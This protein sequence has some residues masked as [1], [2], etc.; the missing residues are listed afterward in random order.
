[1]I[2]EVYA[3]TKTFD[4]MYEI[5]YMHLKIA[6][7]GLELRV[8]LKGSTKA[9][10]LYYILKTFKTTGY[11]FDSLKIWERFSSQE[12]KKLREIINDKNRIKLFSL[13]KDLRN[14]SGIDGLRIKSSED[15]LFIG[16]GNPIKT[17]HQDFL[18]VFYSFM[19][20]K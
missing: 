4:S 10:S 2:G 17:S 18:G 3:I 7:P 9:L 15:G 8:S 5:D 19:K 14:R 12:E 20:K 11:K 16:I 13:Y 6:D 1:M